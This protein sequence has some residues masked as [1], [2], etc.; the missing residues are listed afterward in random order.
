MPPANYPGDDANTLTFH[1]LHSRM[2]FVRHRHKGGKEDL[3]SRLGNGD[4]SPSDLFAKVTCAA[5]SLQYSPSVIVLYCTVY[6]YCILV[7]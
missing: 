7:M 5:K 2:Q 1:T 4:R 3:I 6:M